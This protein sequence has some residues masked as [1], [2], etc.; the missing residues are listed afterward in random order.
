MNLKLPRSGE[1]SLPYPR[2]TLWLAQ[3]QGQPRW[4]WPTHLEAAGSVSS[5]RRVSG[6]EPGTRQAARSRRPI[7]PFEVEEDAGMGLCWSDGCF[8][9]HGPHVPWDW[10][11]V[12]LSDQRRDHLEGEWGCSTK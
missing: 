3:Q 6:M 11:L 4:G 2:T 10:P 5:A 1:P 12:G 8:H 9:G 7:L